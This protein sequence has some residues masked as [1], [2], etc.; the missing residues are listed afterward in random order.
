MNIDVTVKRVSD[1]AKKLKLESCKDSDSSDLKSFLMFENG[2]EMIGMQS[3][4]DGHP[5]ENLPKALQMAFSEGMRRFD[6]LSF[7]T[8]VY[9]RER[10]VDSVREY[11]RG[12][13][14]KEF[15]S[16]P[17]TD[18][19]EALCVFT[20]SWSGESRVAVLQY[21][22]DDVGSPVFVDPSET[23]VESGEQIGGLVKGILDSYVTFCKISPT[24]IYPHSN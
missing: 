20:M 6:S 1:V 14:A 16:N 21:K 9:F 3:G 19:V 7:V 13:L 10:P 22:L 8:D 5:V 24:Q 12:D 17:F 4:I 23:V 15:S 18:I 11:E 2:D